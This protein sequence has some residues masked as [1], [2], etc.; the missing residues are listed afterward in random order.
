[1]NIPVRPLTPA[2]SRKGRGSKVGWILFYYDE[3]E[4]HVELQQYF[5]LHDQMN[6][7]NIMPPL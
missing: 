4:K 6:N 7:V 5:A 2:L 1:M 3:K